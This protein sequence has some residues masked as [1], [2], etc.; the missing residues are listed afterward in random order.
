[1]DLEDMDYARGAG[2]DT[3][4]CCL[5]GT[6]GDILTEIESWI[7]STGEDVQRVFWLSGTAGKGKS[8]IAHTL[9][10]WFNRRG[11]PGAFFCFDRTREADRRHE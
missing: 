3:S 7:D 9:A 6:R 8:A 2:R 5:P 1:M 4:K 10:D 11:G